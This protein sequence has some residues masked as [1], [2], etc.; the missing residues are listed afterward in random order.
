M[1]TNKNENITKNETQQLK[2]CKH[3]GQTKH[4]HETK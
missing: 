4:K 2:T 1:K 3:K